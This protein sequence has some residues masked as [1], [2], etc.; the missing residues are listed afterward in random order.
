MADALVFA[1]EIPTGVN[2]RGRLTY[3]TYS[4][5]TR[6]RGTVLQRDMSARVRAAFVDRGLSVLAERPGIKIWSSI[7]AVSPAEC[8]L[9]DLKRPVLPHTDAGFGSWKAFCDEVIEWY[10]QGYVVQ[11]PQP[12]GQPANELILVKRIN[13][14]ANSCVMSAKDP[15]A[16]AALCAEIA[17]CETELGMLVGG[18]DMIT[19]PPSMERIT[20]GLLTKREEEYQKLRSYRDDLARLNVGG[21]FDVDKKGVLDNLIYVQIQILE[22]VDTALRGV[23]RDVS[24]LPK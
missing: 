17:A 23:G 18:L 6:D 14:G 21:R 1:F 3:A 2:A 7:P 10:N 24:E 22:V 8:V 16:Y 11:V 15:K 12:S 13:G 5:S 19:R 20:D 9:D 4:Y